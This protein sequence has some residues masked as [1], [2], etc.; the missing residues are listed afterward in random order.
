MHAV[1]SIAAFI[2]IFGAQANGEMTYKG[3]TTSEESVF[4]AGNKYKCVDGNLPG[5]GAIQLNHYIDCNSEDDSRLYLGNVFEDCDLPVEREEHS[6][7]NSYAY[8]SSC[9]MRGDVFINNGVTT[10]PACE[11][12]TER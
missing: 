2:A 10:V 8:D 9:Q 12:I 4:Y 1:V 3:L 6:Y 7:E 11:P 5:S